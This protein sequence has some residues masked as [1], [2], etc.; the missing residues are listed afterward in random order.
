MVLEIEVQGARQ[1]R[2]RR[3]D[4]R[5]IFLLPPSWFALEAR[6]RGRGTDG[7]EEIARRLRVARG[8]LAAACDFDYGVV[9]DDLD[10]CVAE[11]QGIVAA[12]RRGEAGPLRARFAPGPALERVAGVSFA[13]AGPTG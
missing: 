8:E 1:V 13:P 2:K 5:L 6:L 9:N 4:A 11:L 7:E 3:A 10:T 12:E